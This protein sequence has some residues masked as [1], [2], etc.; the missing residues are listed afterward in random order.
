[1]DWRIYQNESP[2][3]KISATNGYQ[4][5]HIKITYTVDN[6]GVLTLNGTNITSDEI[7]DVNASFIVFGVGNTGSVAN[8]QVR[9]TAIEV[10]YTSLNSGSEGGDNGG[11]EG[12]ETPVCEHTNTATTSTA[13]CTAGG[14]ETVKCND[15]GETVR[16]TNVDALGHTTENGECERCHE[17]I[18]GATE[19]NEITLSVYGNTGTKANDGSSISWTSGDVTVTN[20]KGSTAIRTSDNDHYRVYANSTV[21]ISANGGKITKVVI[22]CT[23]SSYATV[24]KTSATNAGYEVT[25]SGSVV[26]I[27][28]DN[29]ESIT[30]KASA[31]TRMS[32]VEVTY[33]K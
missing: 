7:V 30:F 18:G 20:V 27:T 6:T 8:G 22:T 2:Q 31:Q 5:D 28:V 12:G 3:I 19:S 32:K 9:I 29:A 15:C 21:A 11:S 4:I 24:M 23:S 13:T 14:V 16:T 10:V 25:V 17:T 33:V 26:T 1:M